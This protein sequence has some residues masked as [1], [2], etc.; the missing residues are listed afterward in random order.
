[1][2]LEGANLFKDS[3]V[4]PLDP[5]LVLVGSDRSGDEVL[6]EHTAGGVGP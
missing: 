1:M 6:G 4:V 5:R 2:S 3:V